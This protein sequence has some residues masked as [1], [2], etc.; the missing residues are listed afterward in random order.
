MWLSA[1]CPS[2][3]CSSGLGNTSRTH[4]PKHIHDASCQHVTLAPPHSSSDYS[5]NTLN[6]GV[7]CKGGGLILHAS[8]PVTSPPP[9]HVSPSAMCADTTLVARASNGQCADTTLVAGASN[10]QQWPARA[11]VRQPQKTNLMK[12]IQPSTHN[13]T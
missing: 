8:S 9:C 1:G 10:G 6:P 2:T 3:G 13:L 12:S 4:Q 5:D 7:P 11:T